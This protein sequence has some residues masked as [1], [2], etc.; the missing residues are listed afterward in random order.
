MLEDNKN[1]INLPLTGSFFDAQPWIYLP[2]ISVFSFTHSIT[3]LLAQSCVHLSL[4]HLSSL[5]TSRRPVTLII[6]LSFL[7]RLLKLAYS[8]EIIWS[9]ICH[10]ASQ[11]VPP[12][13]ITH[14]SVLTYTMQPCACYLSISVSQSSPCFTKMWREQRW[15]KVSVCIQVSL[16]SLFSVRAGI[17]NAQRGFCS[18]HTCTSSN[19]SLLNFFLYLLLYIEEEDELHSNSLALQNVFS[20]EVQPAF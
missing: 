3:Q 4:Q 12:F 17:P 19:F 15:R 11:A 20:N 5:F 16:F 10:L 13:T 9:N 18:T 2:V 7:P 8:R 1:R 14:Y 6:K